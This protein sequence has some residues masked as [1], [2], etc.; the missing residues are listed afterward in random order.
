VSSGHPAPGPAGRPVPESRSRRLARAVLPAQVQHRLLAVSWL[1]KTVGSGLYL[2]TSTLYFTRVAGLPVPEVATG[3]AIAGGVALGGAVPLGR[4]ADRVGPRRVYGALLV[5][6][7]ALMASLTTVRTFGPFLVVIVLFL[8]AEQGSTAARGALVAGAGEG[9]ERIRFRAYLRVVTNIGV[10]VG[11]G[12]AALAIQAGTPAAYRTL[13]LCT[14]LTYVAAAVPLWWLPRDDGSGTRAADP[15]DSAWRVLRDKRYVAVTVICGVLSLQT[16][17]LSFA[18]PIWIVDHTSAPPVLVSAVVV[19][20]AVLVV[21]F[22][23]RASRGAEDPARAA[24]LCLRAGLALLLSCG[25]MAVTAVAPP[26]PVVGLLLLFAVVLTVGELWLSAGSFG[27]GFSLAP[28]RAHGQYQ[29]FFS[30]GRGAV[31]AVAPWLLTILCLGDDEGRGWLLLG[32][33]FAVAGLLAPVAAS[34][35]ARRDR[36]SPTTGR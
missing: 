22:Q 26:A 21:L 19:V 18:V 11:A 8:L 6:Q 3:L 4:I 25:L 13:L 34:P 24:R 7:F 20:N 32:G 27:L 17:V 1:V 16:P 15:A 10:T 14:A 23:V 2:P 29:G 30:I 35:A 36:P 28:D 9:A 5:I 31:A 33:L 12:V